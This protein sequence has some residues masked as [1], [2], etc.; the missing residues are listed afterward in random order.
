[1]DKKD[2]Q[3]KPIDEKL[4]EKIAKLNSSRVIKKITP[5]GDL[6]WYIKWF[7]S[8]IILTGMVLTSANVMPYNLFF[9]LVGVIGWG[10]VGML[11]HDRALIFINGVATFIFLSG[12]I[13]Y[14]FGGN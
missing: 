10:I 14:Y 3:I 6:S 12:I 7:S 13:G 8:F 9:H 2:I 11:W 5:R 4:D 1:M